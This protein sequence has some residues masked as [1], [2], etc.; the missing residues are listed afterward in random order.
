MIRQVEK[1]LGNLRRRKGALDADVDTREEEEE[2]EGEGRE[3]E[4]ATTAGT[5]T[6]KHIQPCQCV[7]GAKKKKRDENNNSQQNVG[8]YSRLGQTKA[9]AR[10]EGCS[11]NHNGG[12]CE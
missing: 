3:K 10:Q 12:C 4:V 2:K 11:V 7:W 5:F 8:L 6:L 9:N 1:S